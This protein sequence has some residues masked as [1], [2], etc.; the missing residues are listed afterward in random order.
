MTAARQFGDG[1]P[2][3]ALRGRASQQEKCV[4][5]HS[6]SSSD[7]RV[8]GWIIID[9]FTALTLPLLGLQLVTIDIDEGLRVWGEFWRHSSLVHFFAPLVRGSPFDGKQDD[10]TRYVIDRGALGNW[11]GDLLSFPIQ[12]FNTEDSEAV[13]S[14]LLNEAGHALDLL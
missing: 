13:F 10:R 5:A 9:A 2:E 1:C 12:I 3:P 14:Q 8:V 11:V 6:L 4:S 7:F